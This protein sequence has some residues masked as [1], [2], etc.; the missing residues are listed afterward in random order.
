MTRQR[1]VLIGVLAIFMIASPASA[2]KWDKGAKIQG[3]ALEIF[4]GV[5]FFDHS[6]I[7]TYLE[8]YRTDPLSEISPCIGSNLEFYSGFVHF[9]LML[10]FSWQNSEG[11]KTTTSM[12]EGSGL[13][14]LGI[15]ITQRR[16]LTYPYV[17]IG[18]DYT[19]FNLNTGVSENDWFYNSDLD[20]YSGWKM[21]MLGDVGLG[22][23]IPIKV[24][25]GK[26]KRDDEEDRKAYI[27]I[28]LMI[29]AGYE[30]ELFN[31]GW[32]KRVGDLHEPMVERFMGLYVRAGIGLG[33][34]TEFK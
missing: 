24:A 34:I 14:H 32:Q 11:Y 1:L 20:D 12:W 23:D 16:V 8:R 2:R 26:V 21:G 29:Q 5:H 15:N 33:K 9:D 28:P 18:L 25:K 19:S 10:E 22:L 7:N 6:G 30:G 27:T 13:A 3:G 17:G 31:T 4:S